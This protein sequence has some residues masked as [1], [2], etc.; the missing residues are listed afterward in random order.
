[1][2]DHNHPWLLKHQRARQRQIAYRKRLYMRLLSIIG[3][4]T[5]LLLLLR[6]YGGS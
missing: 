4:F 2:T 1:M 3:F 5:I 6:L